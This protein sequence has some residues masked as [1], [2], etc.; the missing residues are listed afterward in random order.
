MQIRQIQM[1]D[2][3]AVAQIIRTVMPEFGAKGE[4]FSINDPEVDNMYEAYQDKCSAFYVVELDS[5]ILGCGGIAPLVGADPSICELKKMYFLPSLRGRGAGKE[6]LELC[7]RKAK[8]LGFKKC[9]LETLEHMTSA[10]A[11]YESS[12]F[13]K[14]DGPMGQTGHHGCNSWYLR[15]L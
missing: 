6:L 12:G 13:E 9:Y 4:G 1:K 7:L 14:I 8:E 11:L 2:N 10:R 3:K 5:L 15:S